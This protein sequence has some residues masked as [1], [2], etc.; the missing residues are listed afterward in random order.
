MVINLKKAVQI[1]KSILK[2]ELTYSEADRW[3]WK[4]MQLN[5]EKQLVFD[6]NHDETL[7]WELIQYLYGLDMPSINDRSKTARNDSD[8][9]K[10]LIEKNIT[11]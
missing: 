2:K 10:F 5:D 1:Y 6:P 3:A 4:M 9:K 11:F 7:I 8:I